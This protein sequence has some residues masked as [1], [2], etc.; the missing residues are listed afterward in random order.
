MDAIDD[1]S[2]QSN[3]K[4]LRV[5]LWPMLVAAAASVLSLAVL[6]RLP[7][8][9]SWIVRASTA[10]AEAPPQESEEVGGLHWEYGLYRTAAELEPFRRA[11]ASCST[12]TGVEAARCVTRIISLDSPVGNPR[13]EFVDS[14][15]DPSVAL[16][17]H[18]AGSPGHCT[19]R[20]A[21]GAVALLSLGQAARIAQLIPA[22]G[23]GHNVFEVFDPSYGWVVFDPSHDSSVLAND[24]F[25]SAV[26][27]TDP[28]TRLRYR[29][30]QEDAPDPQRYAG[31]TINY[32]E[33]WLYTRVGNRCARWPFRGCFAQIGA[34]QFVIGPAQRLV[35]SIGLLCALFSLA[36][37]SLWL[38]RQL[39]P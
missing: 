36:W 38:R 13:T 27:M 24:D 14:T 33:P 35:L 9:T 20:S 26:D 2:S 37:F 7:Y 3:V 18:L 10:S 21:L 34:T 11:F 4:L 23:A 17:D 28:N 1:S 19:A 29:R 5:S 32:P 8:S 25:A 12:E 15:F 16:K 6:A 31:A 22:D 39:S 30:P